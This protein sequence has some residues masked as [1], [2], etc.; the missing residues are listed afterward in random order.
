MSRL[1]LQDTYIVADKHKLEQVVRNLVSNALKFTPKDGTVTIR[2]KREGGHRSPSPTPSRMPG[3]S[4]FSSQRLIQFGSSSLTRLETKGAD[5]V[6]SPK[7]A[8][9]LGKSSSSGVSGGGGVGSLSLGGGVAVNAFDSVDDGDMDRFLEEEEILV[10]EVVDT[11][12]GISA[13]GAIKVISTT[14]YC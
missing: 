8:H 13:V 3:S 11:G 7:R 10:V 5:Q 6:R 12:A 2:V 4:Y 14:P 1:Y 9:M